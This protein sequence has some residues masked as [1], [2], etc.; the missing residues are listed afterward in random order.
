M[1]RRFG[2]HVL[3]PTIG[4]PPPHPALEHV[5]EIHTAGAVPDRRLQQRVAGRQLVELHARQSCIDFTWRN[6]SSAYRP[7]SRPWPDCL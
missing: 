5:A 7:S 4:R 6:S 2:Q 3:D 1:P